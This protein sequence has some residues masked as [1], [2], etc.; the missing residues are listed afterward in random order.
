M[1]KLV[2]IA[3]PVALL[4]CAADTGGPDGDVAWECSVTLDLEPAVFN[5]LRSPSGSGSG[6]G[7]GSTREEAL[8][9]AYAQACA[10]LPISGATL[11]ACR[12]GEEFVVEGGGQGNIILASAV[13]RS[14]SCSASN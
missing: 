8:S 10:Q 5:N 3:V 12:N 1:N 13:N 6:S 4:A 7:T 14:V 9:T 11:Q 2:V